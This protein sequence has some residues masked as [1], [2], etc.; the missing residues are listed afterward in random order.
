MKHIN[1]ILVLLSAVGVKVSLTFDVVVESLAPDSRTDPA[2]MDWGTVRVTRVARNT[3]TISGTFSTRR[4]LGNETRMSLEVLAKD[5]TGSFHQRLFW[6]EQPLCEFFDTE[7]KYFPAVRKVS[8]F[9]E[10]GTC[11]FPKMD[12]TVNGFKFDEKM[13]PSMIPI[14]H[15]EPV[16]EHYW[17]KRGLKLFSCL[18]FIWLSKRPLFDVSHAWVWYTFLIGHFRQDIRNRFRN[19]TGSNMV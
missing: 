1:I 14:G 7:N 3:F 13:M 8:N 18:P 19:T 16:P 11:P 9:P 17:F 12:V 2:T 15:P 10:K 4:A 6:K 5:Y